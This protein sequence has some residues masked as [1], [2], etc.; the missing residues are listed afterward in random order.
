MKNVPFKR[1]GFAYLNK[2]GKVT[3]AILYPV[4]TA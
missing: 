1:A 4:P 3:K 2:T